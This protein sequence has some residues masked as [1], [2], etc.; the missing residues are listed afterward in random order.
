MEEGRTLRGAD[1]AAQSPWR[2]LLS[3]RDKGRQ[4]RRPFLRTQHGG[5]GARRRPAR[6]RGAVPRAEGAQVLGP[7]APRRPAWS[8]PSFPPLAWGGGWVA[9][10]PPSS[11]GA[12]RLGQ[13]RGNSALEAEGAAHGGAE[14]G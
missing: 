5:V 11:P 3:Q 2:G 6:P 1:E 12:G 10:G 8:L 13:G 7:E 4:G 14:G 9:P